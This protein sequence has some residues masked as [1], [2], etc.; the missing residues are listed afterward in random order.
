M[1]FYI[2][3]RLKNYKAVQQ[4][5]GKLKSAGW[6]HTHD[7][8]ADIFTEELSID[9][10]KDIGEK[11]YDGVKSADVVIVLTPQGGGTHTELG[12]A[13]ALNKKVVICH[14]E[15]TYF[16]CDS[17]T[18]P[19]YWLPQVNRFIGSVDDVADMLING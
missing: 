10:L 19:F 8:T 3:S 18:S 7:W 2:A 15:D 17:N 9:I 1:K 14:D 12:M 13:I 16:K 11:E 4:L 6:V 5:S